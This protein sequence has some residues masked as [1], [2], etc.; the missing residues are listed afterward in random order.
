LSDRRLIDAYDFVEKLD[1][2]DRVVISG[3]AYE[4]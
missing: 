2:L 3:S 1:T 4:P